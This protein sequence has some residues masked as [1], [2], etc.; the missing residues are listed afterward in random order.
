LFVDFDDSRRKSRA[1]VLEQAGYEVT[2]RTDWADAEQASHEGCFDLVL[3]A[4]HSDI[5]KTLR[6][7]DALAKDNPDLPVLLLSDYGVFVPLGTFA[8]KVEA[9][10]PQKLMEQIALMLSES[11]HIRQLP[12]DGS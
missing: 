7:G 9:G 3:I 11:E 12:G 2:L 4:L 6:Y 1:S 8:G 5:E 10:D